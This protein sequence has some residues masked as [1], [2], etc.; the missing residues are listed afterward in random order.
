MKEILTPPVAARRPVTVERHGERFEDPFAWLRDKADPGVR[1]YLEAENAYA[2]GVLAGTR[3]LQDALYKEMLGRIKQTDLT[4]P[5]REGD[6]RYYS[7]TEE[8]HQYP[9]YCRTPWPD[10]P[11]EVLLDLNA[12]AEGKSFM[13]LGAFEPSDDGRLL[14]YSTDETGFREYRLQVKDLRS[15]DHLPLV[16]ERSGTVAW[17]G[18]G[19]TLFYTVDDAAKRPW[20]LYRH[21][22]ESPIPDLIYEE[23]DEAFR[24][25][26]DRTRSR[27]FLV[28]VSGSHTT[29]ECRVL[30]ADQP[31]GEWRLVAA[32]R[33]D[34][35]YD[36]AHQ[37][38]RWLIRVND[39]G[40]TFRLVEAPVTDPDP[41]RWT[42]LLPARP[43]VMLEGV[44]A[45]AG[46]LVLSERHGGLPRLTVM[47]ASGRH[48]VPL[49]DPICEVYLGPNR[50]Y[51]S[52]R[53]RYHYQSLTVPPSVYDYD[54]VARTTTLL[55]R[56]EVLGGYDEGHYRTERLHATAADGTRIP[57]SI[58]RAVDRADVPGPLL[59]RG[60]GSYGIPYP[61]AFDSNR[62]SLL[63]RGVAIAIAHIRGGG[64]LG[65]PW[66]DQGR[67]ARKDT[68][69]SDFIAVAEHLIAT[70]WT[71][72]N[73]LVI[74]G[75]SAGGLLMGAVVN[76]RPELF[77][78][79]ISHVPF[80][81]VL[82]T[83][84]D[85]TL[86]LTVGEYEEW[87]NPM[88]PEQFGW[89]RAYCPYTNLK[90]A[91]F[92][93]MLVRTALNDS[94]VMYWEPA[95]Y[96]ARLRELGTGPAP[97]LLV[98]NLGAGH[99]GASGR[100]DRLREIALD[101]AFVLWVLGFSSDA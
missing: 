36:L 50:E 27:A 59:L 84:S 4:V 64:E 85:P 43:D 17:S 98:T 56:T 8:G 39:T 3:T 61:I 44:D 2:E 45:F 21:P 74:E 82:N 71:D 55:K 49:P 86:P 37:D 87:G 42:E 1:D 9:V 13:A 80:V 65:K 53:I 97:I 29:T 72:P 26:V 99:S 57:I 20:R 63:D 100:Y 94:Q 75:G 92:P 91:A 5:Y 68:T 41:D 38:D 32:R 23:D 14:A 78:A 101:Y 89:M 77:R 46:R 52:A 12:L 15:G 18:D 22:L 40:R 66:H 93:A 51:G 83:M 34:I 58:V 67:M 62:V 81:D 7:R 25:G 30:E 19:R 6:Y 96:V 11:E 47:D 90:P 70:R 79:V 88:D 28:L 24:V 35:E 60:Y 31:D 95:K 54:A 73:H 16:V 76:R 10:G 69:F 48:P 33:A